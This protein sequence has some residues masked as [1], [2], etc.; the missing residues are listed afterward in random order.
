MRYALLLCFLY[1]CSSSSTDTPAGPTDG[2]TT[3]ETSTTSD[4][5]ATDSPGSDSTTPADTAP[6]VKFCQMTCSAPAD[7]VSTGAAFDADNYACESGLCK[8][9]GCN[10]NAECESTFMSTQYGCF[11]VS[12]TKTCVKKCSAPADC[13]VAGS[14]AYDADNW[15][16]EGGGC[17]WTGCNS[18]SE[19]TSLG[20]YVC[21]DMGGLKNCVKSCT[22]PSDCATMSAAFDADNYACESG[23]CRYTGC[24]TDAECKSS[25]MKTNYACR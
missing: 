16:C 21:R 12:G 24:N 19:C 18:D 8:Y 22:A 11:D 3:D 1:G 6:S 23:V 5:T 2:A 4:S 15:A 17:R 25:L 7:C 9:K 13:A 14:A 20:A 10:S